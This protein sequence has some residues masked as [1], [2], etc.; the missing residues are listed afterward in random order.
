MD[1]ALFTR[2]MAFIQAGMPAADV[3]A[4]AQARSFLASFP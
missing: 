1:R 2:G 4:L 3:A